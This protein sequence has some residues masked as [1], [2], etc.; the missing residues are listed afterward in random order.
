V[1]SGL[2]RQDR[3]LLLLIAWAGLSY[4]ESAKALG[5]PVSTVRSRLHRIRAKTRQA[6]GGANPIHVTPEE[7]RNG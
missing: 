4:E 3:E 6:L 2:A 1:L 7:T 5:V